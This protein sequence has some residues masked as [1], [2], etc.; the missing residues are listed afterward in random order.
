MPA[1]AF[2]DI[3]LAR[4]SVSMLPLTTFRIPSIFLPSCHACGANIVEKQSLIV[5]GFHRLGI[6]EYW[7]GSHQRVC[8]GVGP[9]CAYGTEIAAAF[10][11]ETKASTT[12]RNVFMYLRKFRYAMVLRVS[13]G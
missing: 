10:T 2:S 13:C 8:H 4:S 7:T 1:S 11:S 5:R 12:S 9:L 3:H 6:C